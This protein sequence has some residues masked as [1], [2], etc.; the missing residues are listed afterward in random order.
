MS[1]SYT[2]IVADQVRPPT[3]GATGPGVPVAFEYEP[4][5]SERQVTGS[6]AV[7]T[8]SRWL[9]T[10]AVPMTGDQ[11]ALVTLAREGQLPAGA[12]AVGQVTL[13]IPVGEAEAVITLLRGLVVH[14]RRDGVWARRGRR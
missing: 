3:G 4:A 1:A 10:L 7:G 5:H 11:S 9:A 12:P 13:V 6:V 2:L 14:A 8:D